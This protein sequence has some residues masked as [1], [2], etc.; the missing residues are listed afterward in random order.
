M[1]QQPTAFRFWVSQVIDLAASLIMLSVVTA[2]GFYCIIKQHITWTRQ[3][4]R[5]RQ[6]VASIRPGVHSND[7]EER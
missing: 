2:F 1:T 6:T 7:K 3:R 4:W 5:Q